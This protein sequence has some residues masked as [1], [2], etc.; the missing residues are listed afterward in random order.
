MNGIH[1]SLL[2]RELTQALNN[3]PESEREAILKPAIA[4]AKA[5]GT[6]AH[7]G[8]ARAS[9]SMASPTAPQDP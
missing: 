7:A 2:M 9:I 8:V 4:A 1:W 5:R 3:L 6:G